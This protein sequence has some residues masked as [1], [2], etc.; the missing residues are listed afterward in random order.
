[1]A[2][3]LSEAVKQ[4]VADK[5][6]SEELILKTIEMALLAAYKK[7]YGTTSNAETYIDEE[8]DVVKIYSKK[9]IVDKVEEPVF[10]IELSEAQKL[11]SGAEVGDEMLIEIKPEDF[12]R[13][14]AQTAKQV[15]RQRLKEIEKDVV[16][17][18][19][20]QR[21]GEMIVGY[22]QRE[23]TGTI[24]VN[25]GRTEGIMPRNQQSPREHYSIGDRIKAL[26]LEVRKG[27]KGPQIILSRGHPGFVK[28]IFELEIPEVADG[29]IEIKNI[30]R[31][32]G[33]RT[34]V[35]VFS[36]RDE[37]DPVGACV[38]MKGIRIQAIVGEL[39][40]EKIDIVKWDTDVKRYIANG[41]N[42][43]KISRIVV[44]DD[45]NKE[46]LIVVHDSQLSIAIGRAGQNIRLVSKLVGWKLDIMPES[47]FETSEY[48]EFAR[49]VADELFSTGEEES[50]IVTLRDIPGIDPKTLELLENEGYTEIEN[51]IEKSEKE[52]LDIEGMT[53]EMAKQFM[54]ILSENIVVVEEELIK[55]EEAPAESGEEEEEYYECPNCGSRITEEMSRCESCGVELVFKDEEAEG[56]EVEEGTAEEEE[57]EKEEQTET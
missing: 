14:A 52:L 34:K 20:K 40:G 44:T 41:M 42:P 56:E 11:H 37:V 38:G 43:V 51:I 47:E 16:Y 22:F 25:L 13:I 33:Y 5:G 57:A 55:T 4:L 27:T 7:K 17:N 49:K 35:A 24:Y 1:M 48:A 15:V 46:A 45:K 23:R 2:G 36:P 30:V 21:E 50:E 54:G 39:E 3:D 29:T 31:D 8:H 28:K 12:G 53:V 9:E 6:I 18:E 10:E 19:F 32:P 26:L